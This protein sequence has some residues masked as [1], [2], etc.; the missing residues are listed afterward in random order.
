MR[1]DR[2]SDEDYIKVCETIGS[3]D[4]N[5]ETCKEIY[6]PAIAKGEDI[7][8]IFAPRHKASDRCKS[9]KRSHCTCDSCF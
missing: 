9:G 3:I 4:P 5:C 6:Y 1:R 2:I 7:S 8:S